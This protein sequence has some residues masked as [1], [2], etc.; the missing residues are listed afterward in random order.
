[1]MV[2]ISDNSHSRW[3]VVVNISIRNSNGICS[4]STTNSR[5]NI[6]NSIFTNNGRTNS[7]G[8]LVLVLFVI[9]VGVY[10]CTL[11]WYANV[12]IDSRPLSFRYRDFL[13]HIDWLNEGSDYFDII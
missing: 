5:I 8:F 11:W 4:F 12:L 7:G 3:V 9:F 6:I 2:I 10:G 13:I 1:M